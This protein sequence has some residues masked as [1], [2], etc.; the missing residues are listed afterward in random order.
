MRHK[1]LA[2]MDE[3]NAELVEREELIHCMAMALLARVNLF[4]LGAPGQAKSYAINAFRKRIVGARQFERLLSKQTDEEA[5]FGRLDLASL[6][7]GAVAQSVLN[8]DTWYQ[9]MREQLAQKM[10]D[11]RQTE[12]RSEKVQELTDQM[13]VYRKALAELHSSTPEIITEGKIPEAHI[14]YLDEIFKSSDGVLNSLLTALNERRYTNEGRTVEIP[15]IS[16]FAASNEIPNFHNREEQI[17]APLYDRF[18]F[19]VLTRDIQQRE[20]RLQM[21]RRKQSLQPA[22]TSAEITLDEL[23]AMQE[24]V[25]QILIPETVNERMDDILCALR[26]QGVTVSDR[27]FLRY[28]QIVRAAA[29]IAGHNPVQ[30][31]DLLQL[32]NYLWKE[33]GEIDAVVQTLEKLCMNPLEH[34]LEALHMA[35]LD[36]QADF[37]AVPADKQARALMKFRGEMVQLYRKW[38][39]L[40]QS[41]DN[42]T[43]DM[44]LQNALNMLETISRDVHQT[45]QFTYV[46]LPEI[47]KL[48]A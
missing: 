28:G 5:L 15:T 43:D 2:V 25:K 6:I 30:M 32:K 23:L 45:A 46:T 7:P 9:A 38:E 19:K 35:A 36:C 42:P 22:L 20:N 41:A 29:W 17:L 40:R 48:T 8:K 24:E 13:E 26:S 34:E 4:I 21:L 12:E 10:E 18:A 14:V 44:L 11:C 33:P 31:S 3:L 1:M 16:F 27:T 37:T 39:D 47:L